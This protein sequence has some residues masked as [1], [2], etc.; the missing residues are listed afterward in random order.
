MATDTKALFSERIRLLEQEIADIN[1]MFNSPNL[2][3][4]DGIARANITITIDKILINK[5]K[6]AAFQGFIPSLTAVEPALWEL[7][8]IIEEKH[9]TLDASPIKNS[10]RSRP[11]TN[12]TPI[13]KIL[14]NLNRQMTMLKKEM[15]K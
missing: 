11:R 4:N 3:L 9:G 13:Q 12:L 14:R 6:Q 8:R 10:L 2:R 7:V 1:N 5:L 15:N